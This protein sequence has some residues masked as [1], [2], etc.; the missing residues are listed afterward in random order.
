LEFIDQLAAE[1]GSARPLVSNRG[2]IEAV[3]RE[4]RTLREHYEHKLSRY[5]LPRRSAAD[6]LLLKVFTAAPRD[7]SRPRAASVLRDMRNTLRKQNLRSGAF[8]E[9]HHQ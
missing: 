3:T 4:T 8:S 1:I 5:R 9:Y 7:R 2:T 6:E